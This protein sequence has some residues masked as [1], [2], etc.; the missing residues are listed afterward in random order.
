[1]PAKVEAVKLLAL[2]GWRLGFDPDAA[3][4]RFEIQD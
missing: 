1:M 3:T 2:S 4:R